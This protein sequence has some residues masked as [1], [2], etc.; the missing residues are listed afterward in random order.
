MLI[1]S[2]FSAGYTSD[3]ETA[4]SFDPYP[5][6]IYIY[7]N[8]FIGGG[9]APDRAELETV[10]AALYGAEG[11]LPDI[12]WDG[13]V[14]PEK[15]AEGGVICVDNAGAIVLNIDGPNNNQNVST[16]M[17]AHQCSHPKLGEVTLA[18]R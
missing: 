12:V 13:Y 1:S 16:D 5:E 6:T 10:R 18:V 8:T 9:N 2:Y 15:S 11:S 7:G 3:R 14:D 17:T 4:A